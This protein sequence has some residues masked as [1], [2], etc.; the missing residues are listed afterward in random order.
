[1]DVE[2]VWSVERVWVVVVIVVVLLW[3]LLWWCWLW[4]LDDDIS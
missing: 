4:Y 3:W 1:M 2:K